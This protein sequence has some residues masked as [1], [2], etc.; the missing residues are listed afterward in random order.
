MA[1][2]GEL[3]CP[4]PFILQPGSTRL[5]SSEQL[6]SL[7]L[8]GTYVRSLAHDLGEKLAVVLILFGLRLQ[9]G[10]F[11]LRDAVPLKNSANRSNQETVPIFEFR[12]PRLFQFGLRGTQ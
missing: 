7:L 8:L 1:R 2:R 5:G 4:R 3:I 9:D 10:R 12:L 6:S 11:T